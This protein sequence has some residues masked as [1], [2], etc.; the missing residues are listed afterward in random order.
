MVLFSAEFWEICI[1][2]VQETFYGCLSQIKVKQNP[3]AVSVGFL[4]DY[5]KDRRKDEVVRELDLWPTRHP[6]SKLYCRPR[7]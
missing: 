4:R 7:G 2:K 1:C 6:Y 5:A 3:S